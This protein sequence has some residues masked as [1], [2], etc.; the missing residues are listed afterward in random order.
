MMV[1][2]RRKIR[3]KIATFSRHANRTSG[4]FMRPRIRR[5]N[6]GMIPVIA[7]T[8]TSHHRRDR[9]VGTSSSV[10]GAL[11]TTMPASLFKAGLLGELPGVLSFL[12]HSEPHP[13]SSASL[14]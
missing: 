3:P 6:D 2:F 4:R 9:L 14:Y 10:F 13:P 8:I 1:Q 11:L 7:H 12:S 5:T